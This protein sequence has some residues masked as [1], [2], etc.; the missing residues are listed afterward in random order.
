[1]PSR[2]ERDFSAAGANRLW[3][4]DINDV[5]TMAG[6]LYLAVVVDA[7]SR[8]IVGWALANHRRAE[9]VLDAM[10]M[11]VGQ[12]RPKDVIHYRDQGSQ[13]T[14]GG[15]RQAVRRGGCSTLNGVMI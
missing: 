9:R 12:W 8:K 5:P 1:V 2:R 7:W 11:V 10:E 3:V 4:A 14:S 6:F 13:Y 15:V